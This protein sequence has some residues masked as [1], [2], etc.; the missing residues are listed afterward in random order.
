MVTFL[1]LQMDLL[2]DDIWNDLAHH[3]LKSNSKKK[4]VKFK[5]Y[6]NSSYFTICLEFS[7]GCSQ[8]WH[9]ESLCLFSR[10]LEEDIPLMSW[11][12]FVTDNFF[13][14]F[15]DAKPFDCVWGAWTRW[16]PC[17]VTCGGGG[18]Q[19]RKRGIATPPSR[20]GA[21]CSVEDAKQ[22]I[23]CS[24]VEKCPE[25]PTTTQG[26]PLVTFLYRQN[27]VVRCFNWGFLLACQF[28][29]FTRVKYFNIE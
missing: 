14:N 25:E 24:R 17:S 11:R 29:T 3:L 10:S 19:S 2:K 27:R 6:L 20:D 12:N 23:L 5:T 26:K 16:T 28:G 7:S 22:T 13:F 15:A 9:H 1:L 21:P 4:P 8:D 18:T